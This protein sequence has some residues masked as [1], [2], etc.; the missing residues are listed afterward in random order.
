MSEERDTYVVEWRSQDAGLQ[1][2]VDQ[3]AASMGALETAVEEVR[4]AQATQRQEETK[5]TEETGKAEVA[6]SK[7]S[8][9]LQNGVKVAAVAA[10]AALAALVGG[11]AASY[12]A[13]V[14]LSQAGTVQEKVDQKLIDSIA[15]TGK[16]AKAARVEFDRLVGV[17]GSATGT[18][19]AI[20]G[21]EA[22]LEA[23]ATYVRLTGDASA[24]TEELD[25]IQKI[26]ILTGKD[27]Q[28]AAK[29]AALARGGEAGPLRKLTS[30]TKEQA[31]AIAAIADPTERA[32]AANRA[33][34][35]TLAGV[36]VRTQTAQGAL[37]RLGNVSGDLTQEMGKV[38][39]KSGG[40]TIVIDGVA[41]AAE[42]LTA[43]VTANSVALQQLAVTIAEDT[44]TGLQTLATMVIEVIRIGRD[45]SQSWDAV[46]MIVLAAVSTIADA[47]AEFAERASAL[48]KGVIEDL[49]AI[50]EGALDAASVVARAFRQED[51]VRQIEG[52][53]ASIKGLATDA[54]DAAATQAEGLRAYATVQRA[55]LDVAVKA[56]GEDLAATKAWADASLAMVDGMASGMRDKLRE[57]RTAITADLGPSTLDGTARGPADRPSAPAGPSG[58]DTTALDREIVALQRQILEARE[59]NNIELRGELESRRILAEQQRAA[60]SIKDEEIRREQELIAAIQARAAVEAAT[61]E[62]VAIWAGEAT[63]RHT[64]EMAQTKELA[65]AAAKSAAARAAAD[66]AA[67]R[68][69]IAA[70]QLAGQAVIGVADLVIKDER[71]LAGIK[72]AF[73]AAQSLAQGAAFAASGFTNIAALQASIQHG[74]AAASFFAVAG[75]AG[76]GG[77]AAS[78][79]GGGGAGGAGGSTVSSGADID[80]QRSESMR[81]LTDAIVEANQRGA[82]RQITVNLYNPTLLADA[83][84]VQRQ[85]AD[86]L[87]PELRRVV[88][89]PRR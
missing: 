22:L 26:S 7:L 60:M 21:D 75:G 88:E 17:I 47:L 64:R 59:A 68:A 29:M 50:A 28:D 35:A 5:S 14:K 51:L 18:V 81:A 24:G 52:A 53:R 82:E 42:Q 32:A 61:Q 36:D 37:A 69:Q 55:S 11:L 6:K 79:G 15:G 10:T 87:A 71:K 48:F 58:P 83:P 39:N 74:L 33:L 76:G 40:L 67:Y 78:G 20:F 31:S 85:L 54:T 80:Q 66:E 70:A 25:R 77:G 65:D 62:Q 19:G 16:S 45:W 86:Q 9:T 23:M 1:P 8:A 73:Q 12:A 46:K 3:L 56:Y 49:S 38:I 30:L 43:W 27:V 84:E 41:A 13:T 2:A 72:G 44:V 63:A 57:A 4:K 34:D 89:E